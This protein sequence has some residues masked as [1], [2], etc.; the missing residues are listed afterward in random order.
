MKRIF[1]LAHAQ[2]RQRA[3]EAVKSAP[4]GFVVEIKEPTRNLDQNALLWAL[5]AQVSRSVVWYG[6]KLT[7]DEW[8]DVFSAA[9]KKSN[10]V[11]G[12]DGGFVVCGQSTSNMS[13]R[14]FSDLC[15]IIFSFGAEQGV[16]FNER[17][18]VRYDLH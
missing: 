5:L 17:M 13:K 14:D 3:V 10:V 6:K 4:D 9:L 8:K 1:I 15:E 7:S 18:G 16:E 11:P 2:A 12:I